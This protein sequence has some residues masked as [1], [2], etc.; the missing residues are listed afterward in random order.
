MR[1]DNISISVIGLGYVGLPTAAVIASRGINVIGVDTNPNVVKQVNNG[2][3]PLVEP[4]LE[5]LIR[6]SIKMGTLKA[7]SS[8]ETADIYLISVP[9]PIKGKHSPDLSYLFDAIN[10]ITELIKS[11]DL[12]ILESTS[13]IGTTEKIRD[14]LAERRTDLRLPGK[15]DK[16][17]INIA[18][19]PE[20]V[21]PGRVLVELIDNDRVIGGVTPACSKK[22]Q[23]F[24][25]LF[26]NGPCHITDSRTAECVKLAENAF[27]DTNIAFANEL[28][29]VCDKN[30]IS[31]WEMINLAN[32]HPRVNILQPGPGVGGHCIAV[33]PWFLVDSAPDLTPLIQTARSINDGKPNIVVDKV[34]ECVSQKS[35]SV[36]GFLGLAYKAN[37]DDLRESPALEIVATLARQL[38]N[39][40]LVC[41]PNID[42]L[43]STLAGLENVRLSD[44]NEC[45]DKSE[46]LV[47][48][49]DHAEFFQIPP[50]KVEMKE[51]IDTRGV[52]NLDSGK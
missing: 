21:L 32:R 40:I 45:L 8:P 3:T 18:Y 33:D 37:I 46:L 29:Q 51:I 34:A 30:E 14:L 2:N 12:I 1:A 6:Q 43:P 31:V 17:D 38:G 9:T 28:A 27:R 15:D 48:L 52:F 22:T 5:Q 26:V 42:N 47:L 41:E 13:P 11:G 7:V 4:D 20:R 23:S 16:P 10:N 39:Q 50:E 19:S 36:I 35:V 44:L 49:T 24:Y 25:K